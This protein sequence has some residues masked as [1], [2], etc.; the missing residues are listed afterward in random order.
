MAP[1]TGE[2]PCASPSSTA[3]ALC[4]RVGAKLVR[5]PLERERSAD[6]GLPK[7]DEPQH[8]LNRDGRQTKHDGNASDQD[9]G[10][11]QRDPPP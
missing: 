11:E 7:G 1:L 6:P 9:E 3:V 10:L 2:A 4:V 8:E 5:Q